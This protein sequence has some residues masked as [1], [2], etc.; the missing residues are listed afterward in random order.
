MAHSEPARPI[1]EEL[2]GFLQSGVSISIGTRDG[3]LAP[4]GTRAWAVT[5]DGDRLHVTAFLSAKTAAPLLRDLQA[6]PEVALVF[7]RP[8]DSRACQ[9]K[10]T[11]LES[12]RGRAA[13]RKEIDRQVGEFFT[14]LERIGFPPKALAGWTMWP[15]VA[16]RMRITDVFHQTP[17]P[18]AGE[19]MT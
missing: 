6:H 4:N 15:V 12:R 5:V 13:E 9:I 17:G 10:G 3:N 11:Y 7:D 1:S 2:A 14:D 8:S 16:I 18:G 19:R